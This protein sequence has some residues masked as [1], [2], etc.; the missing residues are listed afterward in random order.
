M[1]SLSTPSQSRQAYLGLMCFITITLEGIISIFSDTSS[2]IFVKL[3]PHAHIFSSSL[4]SCIISFLGK[5]E[6]NGFR[7]LFF[8]D[9]ECW[10]I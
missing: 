2:P 8:L 10:D 4:I 1:S 9:H 7:P 6:G 5:L 3:V